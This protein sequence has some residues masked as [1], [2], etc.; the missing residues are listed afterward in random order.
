[1][2]LGLTVVCLLMSKCKNLHPYS[3]LEHLQMFGT[4]L[5]VQPQ[6]I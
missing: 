3:V 2:L 4:K 5:L 1:M 6:S